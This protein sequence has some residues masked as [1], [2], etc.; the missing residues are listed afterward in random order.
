MQA[1]QAHHDCLGKVLTVIDRPSLSKRFG[2]APDRMNNSV[3][4]DAMHRQTDGPKGQTVFFH[5]ILL[6][7]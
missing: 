4:R 2:G 7:V 5:D 6:S 1:L 3:F